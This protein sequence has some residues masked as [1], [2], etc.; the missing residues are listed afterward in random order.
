[1]SF[2]FDFDPI[3]HVDFFMKQLEFQWLR[4]HLIL[5]G[6]RL[7]RAIVPLHFTLLIYIYTYKYTGQTE[8]YSGRMEVTNRLTKSIRR[9]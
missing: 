7:W 9:Y 2:C 5:V 6:C 4:H 3:I 8:F 1:M